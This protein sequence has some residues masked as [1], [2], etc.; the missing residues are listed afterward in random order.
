MMPGYQILALHGNL[1][2]PDDWDV[3][4]LPEL[5]KMDLWDHADLSFLE[6]AHELATNLSAGMERPILAGYSLGGRLALHAMAIHPERW[7]G[8]VIASAHPGLRSGEERAARRASDRE[9]ANRARELPWEEFLE[10]WN[11]QSVFAEPGPSPSALALES[12]R[13]SVALAFE[14]WSLG[15]QDD[16]RSHLR[17]FRA[18]VLWV[19]G[20]E[21]EK[22]TALGREMES[23]FP[24]YR[25]EVL[26]GHG[27]RVLGEPLAEIVSNWLRARRTEPR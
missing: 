17:R 10:L 23:V 22:F 2:L 26:P 19:T 12:R 20:E 24:D 16:L 7:G 9:W 13:E 21:D 25:H 4:G 14:T 8:A 18:P 15:R 1:G 5:R 11:R 6:F 3:L 27:H